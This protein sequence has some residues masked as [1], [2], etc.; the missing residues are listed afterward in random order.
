MLDSFQKADS[1]AVF[2]SMYEGKELTDCE[3]G[4]QVR[5]GNID[6]DRGL[7]N[8]EVLN[9]GM[10]TEVEVGQKL[11]F[12]LAS[13]VIGGGECTFWERRVPVLLRVTPEGQMSATTY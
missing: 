1:Q 10:F 9:T 11:E 7:L 4:L 8:A 13:T 12:G 5:L 2:A 6:V 3:H